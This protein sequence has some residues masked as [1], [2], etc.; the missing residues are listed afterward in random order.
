VFALGI[1]FVRDVELKPLIGLYLRLN[2]VLAGAE[3]SGPI[4]LNINPFCKLVMSP[5][6]LWVQLEFVLLVLQAFH[7]LKSHTDQEGFVRYATVSQLMPTSTAALPGRS[8]QSLF[9]CFNSFFS[10]F[11]FV[12]CY[13]ALLGT[14]CNS[15]RKHDITWVKEVTL[16]L[17]PPRVKSEACCAREGSAQIP[18]T[19]AGEAMPPGRLKGGILGL[20]EPRFRANLRDKS[21]FSRNLTGTL[22]SLGPT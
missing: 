15:H 13:S 6:F 9:H 1:G 16:N 5:C 11:L 3:P 18:P 12:N 8:R 14:F 19:L 22:L 2:R 7:A 4:R 21:Y 17:P 20:E 10:P